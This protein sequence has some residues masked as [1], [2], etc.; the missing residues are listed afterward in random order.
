M[1]RIVI[2]LM[3][4]TGCVVGRVGD[5]DIDLAWWLAIPLILSLWFGSSK[6]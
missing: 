1:I 6:S 3:F 4:T 2:L 5:Q